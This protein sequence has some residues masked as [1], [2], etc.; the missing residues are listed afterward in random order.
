MSP[1]IKLTAVAALAT[2]LASLSLGPLFIGGLWFWPSAFAVVAAAAG[3]ALGRRAGLLRPAVPLAGLLALG[4]FLTWVY[5]RD[6]AVWWVLPGPAAWDRFAELARAGS[7]I[8]NGYAAPVPTRTGVVLLTAA[9]VGAAALAV[10]TLAVT[11]RNA[12]L[13]GLP[14]FALYAVPV[15]VVSHGVPWVLFLLAALGWLALMLAEGN[16]RILGWG[17]ALGRRRTVLKG[18][19]SFAGDTRLTPEQ[20]G[21][22]GRRIGAA[23]LGIAL[24]VPWLVPG[25]DE[26]VFGRGSGPG[27]GS[28]G[29]RTVLT[30]NPFV[31]LK[32]DLL[33]TSNTP[34]LTYTTTEPKPDYLRMVTLDTFDGTDWTPAVLH[35]AGSATAKQPTP[36][37]LS[38]DVA[39][40]D[41][42]TDVKVTALRTTWLPLPYPTVKIDKLKG[43]WAYDEPTRNVFALQGD[44]LG[45]DYQ[46]DSLQLAPTVEQ[47]R[48]AGPAPASLVARYTA[49][50]AG[51][52]D[53]VLRTAR[54]V[55]ADAKTDFDKALALQQY[56]LAPSSGFTYQLNV[57]PYTG[58]PLVAFLTNKKGYCQQFASAFAV[59]ARSL[60][61]PTR[62][63]VGFTP[64][65]QNSDGSW[66][67]L[68]SNAHAWPEVYFQGVGWVRFEPTPSGSVVGIGTPS[69]APASG[70][71]AVTPGPGPTASASAGPSGPGGRQIAPE[72]DRGAGAAVP[73]TRS[74]PWHVVVVAL[75]AL[76]ALAL[77]AVIRWRRRRH[78][79]ASAGGSDPVRAVQAAWRELADSA[80][81][82]GRPWTTVET[83]RQAADRLAR[84]LP[85]AA[86]AARRLALEVERCRYAPSPGRIEEVAADAAAV[87][88]ELEL[89]VS[90]ADRWRARLL[91]RTVLSAGAAGLTALLDWLDA[92]WSAGW[93]TVRRALPGS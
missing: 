90:R 70:S 82:L 49:L 42:T 27:A 77:P 15:A 10:D 20:I 64:G 3:C 71:P 57:P 2:V 22:V 29:G 1:R 4:L 51:V 14:L 30:V 19:E 35:S 84:E 74:V 67:V 36:P 7:T 76:V 26:G 88:A 45:H 34:V 9:G 43:R 91:P 17:R 86:G 44:T 73:G 53:V 47:L 56:F 40:K 31:S 37:G 93:R 65:K 85:G 72:K 55:T 54:E 66:T 46:V 69:Y 39:R 78:R 48:G 63:D 25:L 58:S 21:L 62:V 6:V 92:R 79:L 28:G 8:V 32:A 75:V 41:V 83:P 12:A 16:D 80:E 89:S 87:L 38:A 60:G 52:P 23:A 81:D 18:N 68:L 59:M 13:A 11:Y 33:S 24:L 5:A 50:P 61:L